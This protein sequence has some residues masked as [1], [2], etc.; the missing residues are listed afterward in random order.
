MALMSLSL[1]NVEQTLF[2]A[3]VKKAYQSRGFILRDYVRMRDN[4]EGN[5]V[6]FRK[7][8]Y[9]TAEQYSFQSQVVYQDPNFTKVNVTLNPYRA[10]TLVDDVERFLYNFDERQ[11]DAM[12]IA[13]ALGRR[14]DQLIIDALDSS[15][16]A[17]TIA[18]GGAGLTFE[19]V[20]EVVEFF[21]NLA[22]PPEQRCIAISAAG[23]SDLLA[24]EE[25]TSSLFLNL[26]AI[27]NGGLNGNF[28]MGM[29]WKVIPTMTE[30]GLPLAG[31]IRSCFAWH[32]LSMGMGVGRNFSTMI[33][34]V[35]QLDS[36]QILGK[37]FA[38][39]VAVDAV[40]IVKIDID[41]SV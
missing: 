6:S 26:D 33:E 17:N 11:E 10:P 16:T 36:H 8:G 24:E 38:N 2:D 15:A 35:P 39:A 25:F 20:R 27:K 30:G 22:I 29:M 23:Q 28:A 32:K 41:E 3:E 9:V 14:S 19:K 18:A 37:M 1:S 12:L 4:V 31:D 13:M 21:D 5:F 34:R 7:V 40:G